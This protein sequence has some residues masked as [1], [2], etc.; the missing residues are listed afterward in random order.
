MHFYLVVQ[1]V[2]DDSPCQALYIEED[3]EKGELLFHWHGERNVKKVAI[4]TKLLLERP[5]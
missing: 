3:L 4:G 2:A 5:T 1:L